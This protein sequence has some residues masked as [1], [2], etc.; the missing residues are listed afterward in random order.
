MMNKRFIHSFVSISYLV[1]LFLYV[2]VVL[3]TWIGSIYGLPFRSMLTVEGIRW[4]LYN[5]SNILL[6][7]SSF[8]EV[9]MILVGLGVFEK[10]GFWNILVMLLKPSSEVSPRQMRAFLASMFIL[11]LFLS[12][13]LL[14]I[15]GSHGVLLGVTGKLQYSPFLTGLP[16]I[17]SLVLNSMGVVCGYVSGQ[18]VSVSDWVGGMTLLISRTS[19]AIILLFFSCLLFQ[20]MDYT[21]LS[22]YLEL[23]EGSLGRGIAEMVIYYTPFVLLYKG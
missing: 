16:M 5:S 21:M 7:A 15:Y 6:D 18:I 10:S 20:L 1:I 2:V 3:S 9:L 14:G 11:L 8:S 22:H 4:I 13:L 12:L 17:L 23:T 19:S